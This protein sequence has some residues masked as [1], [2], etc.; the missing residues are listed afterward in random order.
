MHAG[1]GEGHDVG[2]GQTVL[3]VV[4]GEDG[5]VAHLPEAGGAVGA[6]VGVRAHEDADVAGEGS[7]PADGGRP[8]PYPLQAERAVRLAQHE[9]LGQERDQVGADPDGS[10]SRPAPRRGAWRTSCGR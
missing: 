3:E 7:H 1:L 9:R 2:A 5:V 10:G 4:G 6:D 8:L